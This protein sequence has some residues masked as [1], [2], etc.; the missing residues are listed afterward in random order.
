MRNT[1]VRAQQYIDINHADMINKN[2]ET[3]QIKNANDKIYVY[4]NKIQALN[5]III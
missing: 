1:K 5:I 2:T 3:G 4:K